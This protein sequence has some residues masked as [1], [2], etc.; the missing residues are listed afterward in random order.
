MKRTL[1]ALCFILLLT[2]AGFALYNRTLAQR[3]IVILSTN[4]MHASINNFPPFG[5]SCEGVPRYGG[6]SV[7]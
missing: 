2:P 6:N 4:D 3:E 5:H 7:G 1:Y